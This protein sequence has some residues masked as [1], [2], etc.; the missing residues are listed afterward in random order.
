MAK[1]CREGGARQCLVS[2]LHKDGG[3]RRRAATNDAEKQAADA[4]NGDLARLVV[5]LNSAD[6]Q[7]AEI[8]AQMAVCFSSVEQCRNALP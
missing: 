7:R 4:R 1:V 6:L 2:P 8:M 3:A 5:C